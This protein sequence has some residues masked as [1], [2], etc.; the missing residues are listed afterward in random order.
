MLC[1][2]RCEPPGQRNEQEQ[3]DPTGCRFAQPPGHSRG[4]VPGEYQIR[5]CR[6]T[7]AAKGQAALHHGLP[8][9]RPQAYPL[10]EKRQH[11]EDLPEL[12]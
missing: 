3:F 8:E 9:Q 12:G 7:K 10:G 5:E 11:E 4:L 1:G 2:R 6:A